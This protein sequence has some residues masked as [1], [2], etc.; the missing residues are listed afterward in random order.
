MRAEIQRGGVSAQKEMKF[1]FIYIA[2]T[3]LRS[4]LVF[5]AI[6]TIDDMVQRFEPVLI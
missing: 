3:F 6:A 2:Q 5:S 1:Y 4:F